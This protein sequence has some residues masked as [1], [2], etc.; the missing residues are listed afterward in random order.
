M[1]WSTKRN[2][3]ESQMKD[4]L[5]ECFPDDEDAIEELT[6][7]DAIDAINKHY[8]GGFDAFSTDLGE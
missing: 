5:I 3:L 2:I 6:C 7:N 4:W 8:D 1:E